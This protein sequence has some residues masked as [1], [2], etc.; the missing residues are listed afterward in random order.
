MLGFG[1]ATGR[2][3]PPVRQTGMRVVRAEDQPNR[4]A[5]LVRWTTLLPRVRDRT[6][7]VL[8]LPAR[9]GR[10]LSRFQ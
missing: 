5:A 6:A 9:G 1:I 7:S 8:P 2:E 3:I 10:P 4:R